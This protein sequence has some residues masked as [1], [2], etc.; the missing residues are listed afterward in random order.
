MAQVFSDL[1]DVD[2]GS[3]RPPPLKPAGTYNAT[4][5]DYK[6]DKSKEKQT[7]FV[8]FTVA[9][10]SPGPDINPNDLLHDAKGDGNMVPMDLSKW[11]PTRDFFLTPDALFRLTE[12]LKSC[13]VKLEGRS[14]KACL[15]DAKGLP[16]LV[17]VTQETITNSQTGETNVVN[18]ISDLKGTATQ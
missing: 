5:Q 7:P 17:A 14:I 18:R 16:V 15:P 8:R 9:N 13:G 4:V 6:F 3:V 2:A 1:L 10:M 12:F 11:H